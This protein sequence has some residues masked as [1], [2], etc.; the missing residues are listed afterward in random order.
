MP[1]TKGIFRGDIWIVDF[2]PTE[3]HEQQGKRP[4]V[5]LSSNM[6][7]TEVIEL[8]FVMPGSKKARFDAS[9]RP[10]PNHVRVEPNAENGLSF[11]TFFM[12]EQ[13][14]SASTKRFQAQIGKLTAGQIYELEEIAILLLDLGQK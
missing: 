2:D 11:V 8:A 1:I 13:L 9:G 10:L 6:M 14:R 3:G 4:A 5:V 12:A 7:N